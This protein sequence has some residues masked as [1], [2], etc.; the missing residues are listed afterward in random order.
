MLRNCLEEDVCLYRP[1]ARWGGVFEWPKPLQG[2]QLENCRNQLSLGSERQKKKVKQ[3]LHQHMLFRKVSRK[4]ILTHPK[5]NS[6]IFS[7]QTQLELQMGLA[8]MVRW[9]KKKSFLAAPD[10]F[11]EHGDKKYPMCKT[12]YT[13]VCLMLW[14]Y[15]DAAGG[16]GHLV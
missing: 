1:N 2:P 9:N 16:P 14:A 10:G 11:G 6:C 7:C 15:I 13:A 8:S 4:I 5:T 12:K 3:P